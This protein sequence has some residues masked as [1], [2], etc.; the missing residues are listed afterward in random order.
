MRWLFGLSSARR[1]SRHLSPLGRFALTYLAS[2]AVGSAG[3]VGS[4]TGAGGVGTSWVE[5]GGPWSISERDEP[6]VLL[7]TTSSTL[8]AKKAAARIAV[9]RVRRFAVER[10]V[11]KP[12]MP[13]PPMPSAPP[14]LF[15]SK[16]TPTI[17]SA[18]AT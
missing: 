9:V 17:A 4:G 1:N 7:S 8:V 6:D 11:I 5:A 14:S 10:P 18:M 3:L 13:P 15:C 12:D 16:I 2:G